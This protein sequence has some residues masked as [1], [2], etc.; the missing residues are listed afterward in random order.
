MLGRNSPMPSSISCIVSS[1]CPGFRWVMMDL[2]RSLQIGQF[3]GQH[4]G[5]EMLGDRRQ[6]PLAI[7]ESG[8]DDQM[9]QVANLVDRHPELRARSG[10]AGEDQAGLARTQLIAHRRNGVIGRQRGDLAAIDVDSRTQPDRFI[11]QVGLLE[12]GNLAEIRPDRPIENMGTDDFQGCIGGID[13]QRPGCAC[14]PPYRPA[15]AGWRYG[16][17]ENASGTHD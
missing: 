17:G 8:F 16:P 7:G 13:G 11:A 6:A 5:A 15:T 10:I 3:L 14:R 1:I 2:R 12:A 4:A 9:A